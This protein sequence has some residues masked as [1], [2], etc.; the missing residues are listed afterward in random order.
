MKS[1]DAVTWRSLV[2]V[3]DSLLAGRVS[4]TEGCRQVVRLRFEL[5]EESNE[6]FLPFVGVYS[7]TDAFPLGEVRER[8]SPSAL[9]RQDQERSRVEDHYRSLVIKASSELIAYAG[10]RLQDT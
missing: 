6:L 8:W 4:V 1:N 5:G 9:M 10:L 2:V 7:E 3:L